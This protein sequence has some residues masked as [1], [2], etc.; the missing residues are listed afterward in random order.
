MI[1]L[2]HIAQDLRYALK[3]IR[4][5]PGF[6]AAAILT[7][8]L[9]IGANAAIF[10]VIYSV[11]LRPLPFKDSE[12]FV[13]LW[14]YD[15]S[16]P[17]RQSVSYPDYLD[18]RQQSR[19]IDR[20]SAW[21]VLDGMP[22]TIDGEAER[23]EA[24]SVI[25]DFFQALGVSPMLGSTFPSESERREPQVILSHGYWQRRFNSDPAA[26]GR[27]IT[28]YG[29]SFRV[30]GVMPEKFRFPIQARPMDLWTTLE[31]LGDADSQFLRRNFRGLE[32]MGVLKPTATLAQAQAELDTIASALAGQYPENKGFG[33]QLIPE[34]ENLVGNV[35]RPLIT[36][37][38]A[39]AALLLIACV[40]VANLLLAKAAGRK[41]EMA[42]RG[43]LGA[44]RGRLWAQLLTE[45][46][47]LSLAGG[48]L[49]SLLAV[50]TLDSLV[51]LIPGN[52]PRSNEIVLDIRVLTFALMVTVTAGIGFGL[53]PAWYASRKD[54]LAGLQEMSRLASETSRGKRLRNAL[55]VAEIAVALMLLTGAGL[56]MNSFWRL[57]RLNPGIDSSNVVFFMMNVPFTD[58]VRLASFSR[59][60]QE[61]FLNVPGIRG[62]SVLGSR[63][64]VFGT[65]FEFEGQPQRVDTFTVQPGY[66]R[67]LGIPLLSGR[68]FSPADDDAAPQVAIINQAL[69]TGYFRGENPIG[70][71]LQV[72]VQMTGRVLPVKEIV[73]VVGDTRLGTLGIVE[74]EIQPQIYFSAAQDPLVLSYFGVLVK[75]GGEPG[76]MIPALRAAALAVDKETPI[77]QVIMLKEM[78]GQSIA[79]DRFNTLLL[80]IFSGV[81]LILAVIGLYGVLSYAVAQ[82]TA[83]VGVRI[84]LGASPN[85]VLRLVMLEGWKLTL[86]GTLAGW[87]GSIALTRLIEGLLFGISPTDPLTFGIAILVLA[88]AASLA[89]WIPARRAMRVDPIVALRWQ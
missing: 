47:V 82:R 36:L 31:N 81:A 6:A 14:S 56:L 68:D 24:V 28:I 7:L 60:L 34:L 62:A 44:S 37:F 48:I 49:G 51:A 5:Q 45:S 85:E 12:R 8:A 41:H 21:V 53:A 33:V 43:A 35:S 16:G 89:C 9:G 70:K 63:P 25:G 13:H 67:T 76:A 17:A 72:R 69:A 73:G 58:P 2:A 79:Q 1:R 74:R 54:L 66:M 55:V 77:Y 40:N 22:I 87:L 15:S 86:A 10:S 64:S 88:L 42:L 75:T 26:L 80:G 61:G 30:I 18:W 32:V 57:L 52:L 50:W 65:S 29:M 38:A 27:N 23:V 71:K 46:L 4:K 59:Q 20:M 78:F 11:M 3:T 83:E 19:T 39:V 84:A